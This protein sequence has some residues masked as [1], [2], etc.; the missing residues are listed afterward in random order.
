MIL[1]FKKRKNGT[2]I[3][4][5]T[6]RSL[7][8]H[9][10]PVGGWIIEAIENESSD[11]WSEGSLPKR[12][13]TSEKGDIGSLNEVNASRIEKKISKPNINPNILGALFSFFW[14]FI[15]LTKE[16]TIPNPQKI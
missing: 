6:A 11:G 14:S 4:I 7:G 15:L 10:N 13:T 2:S 12:I 5:V 16:N 9:W 8:F 1:R 3:I